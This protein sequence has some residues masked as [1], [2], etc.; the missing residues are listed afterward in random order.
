MS[1]IQKTLFD[2]G[3][4]S[5]LFNELLQ[6]GQIAIRRGPI[7]DRTPESLD[8][9]MIRDDC[10]LE[11]MLLGVAVGDSLGHSTEW[12]FDPETR[13]KRFGTI[14]DHLSDPSV[15]PGR[16][17]DDTQ[18][19]FWTLERLLA[20]GSFDFDDVV[21]CFVD[22]MN[23]IV[24]RGR[25]TAAALDRH[26]SRMRTGRPALHECVGNVRE[27]GRGNGALMRF[28]PIVFSHLKQPTRELWTESVMCAYA[29][30]GHTCSLA[31]S[32]AM[33]DLLWQA[34][35]CPT[36]DPPRG[37]W[38]LDRFLAAAAELETE[39]LP[40]PLN[41]DPIP[42]WFKQF[43]GTMC[44]FLDST[45]RKAFRDGVPLYEACSL[46]GFGSRADCLQ[47]VPAVLYT[48][49]CH[50]DSF[51]SSMI[52][53]VNDTKDNDTIA[54]IVGAIVGAI[55]GSRAIRRRWLDG[56]RSYSLQPKRQQSLSDREIIEKMSAEAV[57]RFA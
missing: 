23:D 44:D 33:T 13:H 35:L 21:G 57:D 28:S 15:R 34:L 56:I 18:M 6:R 22:R 7:F 49:M 26:Q 9:Q 8:L 3:G 47:T 37:I 31:A 14:L 48:L 53:S 16:L 25:N 4:A 27:E 46:D 54:A 32:V 40:F 42:K 1:D 12:R 41:T 50:A 29:T 36:A 55:H 10:R 38:W 20:R 51:E 5:E 11:G 43:R 45:V 52:A 17:S 2:S 39:P 24:G 19:T 30:H